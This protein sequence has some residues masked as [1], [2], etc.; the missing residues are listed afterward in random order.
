MDINK[1]DKC[2]PNPLSMCFHLG[3][4]RNLI[5][6]D[7]LQANIFFFFSVLHE[8]DDKPCHERWR[9]ISAL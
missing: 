3:I 7:M 1:I 8:D 6:G 5:T 2:I 9:E 4:H